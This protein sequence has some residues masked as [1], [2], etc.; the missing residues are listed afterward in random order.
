VNGT[1]QTSSP[2]EKHDLGQ[3]NYRDALARAV[4]ADV[5]RFFYLNKH[6]LPD[7]RFVHTGVMWGQADK[8]YFTQPK[9]VTPQSTASAAIA[10]VRGMFELLVE[11]GLLA[12]S[13]LQRVN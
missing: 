6:G 1:I 12:P 5:H 13:D 3:V 11:K 2:D 9:A 7:R 4:S 8:A 10:S